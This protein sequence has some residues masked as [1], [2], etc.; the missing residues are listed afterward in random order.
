MD[1]NQKSRTESFLPEVLPCLIAILNDAPVFGQCGIDIVFHEGH[2]SRIV[3]KTEKSYK[4][5]CGG[6]KK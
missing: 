6:Y 2:I 5:I 3:T 1:A 4:A